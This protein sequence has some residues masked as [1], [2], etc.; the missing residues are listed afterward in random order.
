[1]EL[2]Y[3]E[4]FLSIFRLSKRFSSICFLIDEDVSEL[5]ELCHKNFINI[6]TSKRGNMDTEMDLQ[7]PGDEI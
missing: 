7:R 1:M 4:A 6:E 3:E 2:V 5:S